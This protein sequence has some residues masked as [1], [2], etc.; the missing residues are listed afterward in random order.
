MGKLLPGIAAFALATGVTFAVAAPVQAAP[1]FVPNRTATQPDVIKV[2]DGASA[3]TV[4][5]EKS[6]DNDRGPWKKKIRRHNDGGWEA[7]DH[8]DGNRNIYRPKDTPKFA[9]DAYGNLRIYDR[10]RWDG[11]DDDGRDWDKKRPKR[12]HIIKMHSFGIQQ[13]SPALKDVL[14]AV[15][16]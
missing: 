16:D 13:P 5:R 9:Y 3:K 1:M 11:W 7:R 4:R 2:L 8:R 15:P 6:F 10:K 12:P 14:T